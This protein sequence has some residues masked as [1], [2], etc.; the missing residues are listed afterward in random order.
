MNEFRRKP[1]RITLSDESITLLKIAQEKARKAMQQ[2]I[3]YDEV[4]KLTFERPTIIVL[5]KEERKKK[6]FLSVFGD[7]VEGF[8]LTDM[9]LNVDNNG[10]K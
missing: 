9:K 3:S 2:D 10:R 5:Q 1:N 6:R 4:I 7:D 8:H